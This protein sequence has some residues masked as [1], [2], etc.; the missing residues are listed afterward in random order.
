[1]QCSL[2]YVRQKIPLQQG[3]RRTGR[4]KKE[5]DAR[6]AAAAPAGDFMESDFEL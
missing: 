5:L 2:G 3:E 1:M 6:K 4:I